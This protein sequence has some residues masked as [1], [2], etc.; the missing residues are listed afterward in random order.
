MSGAV[1]AGNLKKILRSKTVRWGFVAAALAFGG[2]AIAVQWH[3]ITRA[4]GQLSPLAIAGAVVCVLVAQFGTLRVWQRLLAGL[5][6][7]LPVTAAARVLFIGQL[8]KYVPGS[9]WPVLAQ[10]ELGTVHQVPRHRSASASVLAMLASLLTGL[11]VAA[12][13]LPLTG[14]AGS[15]RWAYAAVPLLLACLHPRVLRWGMDRL[16]RLARQPAL[17]HPLSGPVLARAL[18]WALFAWV[19]NG[20]QIWLLVPVH[21]GMALLLSVGGYAFAWSVGFLVVFAPGGLGVREL[22]LVTT[23]TPLVGTGTATAVA[24]VS[25][26]AT[27]ASDLICAGVSATFRR[28]PDLAVAPA[29]RPDSGTQHESLITTDREQGAR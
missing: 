3:Q 1:L 4:L 8:G 20:L 28:T 23:L 18:G 14:H 26:V 10:M 19:F 29:A 7:P 9:V 24:L 13:T 21:S 12:V 27:T 5:G 15:Y 16:L 25:R 6:S 22:V 17:E 11:L 2:Y